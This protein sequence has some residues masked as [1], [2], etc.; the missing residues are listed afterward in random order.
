VNPLRLTRGS[1]PATDYFCYTTEDDVRGVAAYY[2]PY[3]IQA[4]LSYD[5]VTDDAASLTGAIQRNFS[6][7]QS[8]NVQDLLVRR[9]WHFRYPD[10]CFT[11]GECG[12][13]YRLDPSGLAF[14]IWSRTDARNNC[15][16]ASIAFRGSVWSVESWGSNF[17]RQFPGFD[18]E[19]KQ[20]NRNFNTVLKAISERLHCR[21]IVTVGHSLGGGLAQFVGLATAP[22]RQ[23]SKVVTF[24]SSPVTGINLVTDQRLLSD[25]ATGLTIDRVDQRGEVLSLQ[26]IKKRRQ[27]R[28]TLC[29][30]LVRGVEFNTSGGGWHIPVVWAVDE[31]LMVP[32][33]SR[34]VE[35]SYK[36]GA[37]VKAKLPPVGR[38]VCNDTR[39][40]E[41][42]EEGPPIARIDGQS[43][44]ASD[45]AGSLMAQPSQYGS[46]YAYAPDRSTSLAKPERARARRSV[47]IQNGRRI[48]RIHT[49][50]S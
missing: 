38:Q 30:P 41:E 19:Y 31:H 11:A 50:H 46:T 4:V 2:A 49:A 37:A 42:Q 28:A 25:N 44:Y 5:S 43:R 39:Y 10:H 13:K 14:Q 32:F 18:S 33:T 26:F 24:N 16:E 35:L 36:D 45:D 27:T 21:Q 3:A 7:A 48:S 47:A 20:L 8:K 1:L 34:L 15:R 22:A 23:I 9:G 6:E 29:D 17:E 40:Y 12:A